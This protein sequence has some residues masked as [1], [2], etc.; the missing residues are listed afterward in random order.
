MASRLNGF[1]FFTV[2]FLAP[3]FESPAAPSPALRAIVHERPRWPG[4]FCSLEDRDHFQ[5]VFRDHLAV[6]CFQVMSVP[7]GVEGL[8]EITK[9]AF[10]L[11]ICDITMPGMG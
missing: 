5:E 6:R 11:I 3:L 9:G 10:D 2:D 8:R 4:G 7:S 1:A